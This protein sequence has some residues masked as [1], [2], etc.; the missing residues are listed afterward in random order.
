MSSNDIFIMKPSL[1]N[2]TEGQDGWEKNLIFSV[3]PAIPVMKLSPEQ[4]S[5]TW[6]NNNKAAG[7]I[8][9]FEW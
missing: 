7:I 2:S 6:A 5:S 4:V 8:K 1:I 9:G 3:Y